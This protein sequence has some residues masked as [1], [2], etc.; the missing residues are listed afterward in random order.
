MHL[1]RRLA[2]IPMLCLL[3]ACAAPPA[4]PPGSIDA[5]AEGLPPMQRFGPTRAAPPSRSNADMARDF[6]DL[7]FLMESGRALP[8]LTRFEGP[9]GI[10]VQPGAPA[11]LGRDL[12][13]LLVRL[14]REA[15]IDIRRLPD[16]SPTQIVVATPSRAQLKAQVPEAACFVVPNVGTWEEFLR[17]RSSRATDWT[18]VERR[19]RVA[20][21]I[22]GDVSPQEMRDCLH[23][24]IAQALGPL[25]DLFRLP[26]SVFN[27]DNMH[28]V[29]TGFDMLM[30]RAWY[31]PEMAGSPTREEAAAALPGLLAR[32]NPRGARLPPE[33]LPPTSRDWIDAVKSALGPRGSTAAR[34]REAARALAIAR[35]AGWR[36]T[37]LGFSW[38]VVGRLAV[39]DDP[40]AALVAFGNAHALY[41][42]ALGADSI[43]AANVAMQLAAFALLA[44]NSEAALAL[45]DESLPAARETQNAA[46]LATLLFVR[47]EALARQDRENAAQA[48]RVDSLGWARYGFGTAEAAELGRIRP[49]RRLR[50]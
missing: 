17:Q 29:L 19:V 25:N 38:Y 7:G 21:F 41:R 2:A 39:E 20:V 14:R 8:R 49:A 1:L 18:Q 9:V 40:D 35:A 22:P 3:A 4:T 37:R 16:G 6:L 10:S 46:L 43:Q 23:E 33:G 34:Q 30:L 28:T 24:E 50:L 12:D 42:R 45:I 13:D 44:D 27:D 47:A 48:A 15:G 36:D 31:S 5:A 26:D 11:T 32:L